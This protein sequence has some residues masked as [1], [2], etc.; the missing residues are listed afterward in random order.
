MCKFS[1]V[2]RSLVY[3]HLNEEFNI[4]NHIKNIFKNSRNNY[5]SRKIR[6]ELEKQGWQT[7]GRRISRIM[8]ENGL[9]SNDTIAQYKVDTSNKCN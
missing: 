8:K 2:S 4:T 1:E 9:V 6:V 3:Y 5:G 7:S